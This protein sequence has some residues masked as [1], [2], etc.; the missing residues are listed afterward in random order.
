[1]EIFLMLRTNRFI[2][3]FMLS[4]LTAC[5]GGSPDHNKSNSSVASTTSLSASTSSSTS[6]SSSSTGTSASNTLRLEAEDYIDYYD[7]EAANQAG[8][9]YRKGDGVD[10]ETSTDTG[11]GYDVGYINNG[12]WLEFGIDV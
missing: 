7:T 10:I 11:G 3:L 9:D 8:A 1:M 12:E 6:S 5:G 4:A 2:C